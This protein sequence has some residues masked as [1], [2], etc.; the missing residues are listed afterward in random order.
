MLSNKKNELEVGTTTVV[1]DRCAN[2]TVKF[3]EPENIEM[4]VET[5][6]WEK[7]HS[8]NDPIVANLKAL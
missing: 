8:T 6:S 2:A 4:H 7:T 5:F 1:D 3:V